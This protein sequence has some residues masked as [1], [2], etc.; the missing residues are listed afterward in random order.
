MSESRNLFS[1]LFEVSW[2]V[3]NK[4]GGIYEV[5]T[6]KVLQAQEEFGEDYFLLGPALKKNPDFIETDEPIWEPIRQ[7]LATKDLHCRLGRWNI[8]GKPK[9]ILVDFTNRHN[10]NQILFELWQKY[11]VDSLS[12]GFDYQEP[13]MFSYVCGEVI[14]AIYTHYYA[15]QGMGTLAHFHEWMCGAGLL[16]TKKIAPEVGTIFTTH[17]T[18]LGRAL[19]GTSVDIYKEMSS[20]NPKQAA[21]AHGIT[22]KCSM[23]IISA[24]EADAFTTVS[25]ITAN[26]ASNFLGRKPD[27]VTTN[28][29]DMRVMPNYS[30]ERALA[31][32]CRERLLK[33]CET[34]LRRKATKDIKI[35]TISGRY[36]YHNKGIDLFLDALANLDK[37]LRGSDIKV[38][39]L[40]LVMGGHHGLNNEAVSGDPN[41]TPS[42]NRHEGYITP[43]KVYDEPNDNI[44]NTCK[45]L[46]LVNKVENNVMVIFVPAMLDG[47]DGFFNME[48]FDI[49]AGSDLGV[50]PSWYEPWGYTPHESAAYGV[51]T[52]TTDLSGFGIWARDLEKS[53]DLENSGVTV[54]PRQ[55]AKYDEVVKNLEN[56]LLDFLHKSDDEVLELR[57]AARFVSEQSTWEHFYPLYLEAYEIATENAS[58]RGGNL[59]GDRRR[60]LFSKM[61]TASSSTTPL[62]RTFTA[63]AELP[64][65]I[66]RLRELASNL[67]WVWHKEAKHLF[68]DINPATWN[69]IGHN[70]VLAIEQA[71]PEK[72][73]ELANNATYMERY[74]HV[75]KDFDEY[76]ATPIKEIEGI[77]TEQKPAAYFCC[78]FGIHESLPIYSGGLGILAGDHMKSVSDLALPV[79]GIGLL[80]RNGYFR[81]RLNNE[82]KQEAIYPYND[83]STLPVEPVCDEEGNQ[84]LIELE[85]P[86]R[87]VYAAVWMARVGRAKLYL[88]DTDIS[89]NTNDD[90]RITARLYEADRDVRLRQEIVLGIGG[91]RLC[92]KLGFDPCVFHMNEGHSAF[93]IFERIRK[94]IVEDKLSLNQAMEFV[95]GS[96]VFT[97]HTPVDAG[98]ERF[99]VDQIARYFSSWA[100][101]VGMSWNNFLHLGKMDE[102]DHRDF[103][104]TVLALRFSNKSNGVSWLH[105]VVSRKMWRNLW[106][107]FALA[108]VPISHITNGIHTPS[109]VGDPFNDMLKNYVSPEWDKL[110]TSD[111]Q[112]DKVYSIP[113]NIFWETKLQQKQVLID[114]IRRR[115][116]E[117]MSKFGIDRKHT[118]KLNENLHTDALI[119]GF[120][121]RFAPY[122]RATLL[123][124]DPDRLAHILSQAGR[125]VV[126]VFSGKSHPADEKGSELIQDVVKFACEERFH[127]KIFFV[128]DYSLA[129]SKGLVQG[130]DVWLNNPRRPYEA[131]GTSGQKVPVNGGINFSISDG[132]WCEGY[133]GRNGWTIGPVIDEASYAFTEQ[134]DYADA[135][136]LYTLL[137][138]TLISTYYDR[139]AENIPNKWVDIA[140]DSLR[141]LTA[142]Y[143]T[144]RMVTDYLEKAY[145]PTARRYHELHDNSY[146]LSISNAKWTSEVCNIFNGVKIEDIVITGID[147]DIVVCGQPFTIKANVRHPN[148]DIAHLDVQLVLGKTEG[149]DFAT[150]PEVLHLQAVKKT[151]TDDSDKTLTEFTGTY[152]AKKNGRYA[153]GIRVLPVK[154]GV[155]TERTNQTILWG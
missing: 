123:F 121:R 136:S 108:E 24:R 84:V 65:A 93:L 89:K 8:P 110:P 50:F 38:C 101:S 54:I 135:E 6:S 124:A 119:I 70:P 95:N 129:I 51:P 139:N 114:E 34:L 20:I 87:T 104:M 106:N 57:K 28:G 150:K 40:F 64:P 111:L 23:E 11:G 13:V 32:E 113:D 56:A 18:M 102:H 78:E 72:L 122:K 5:I 2:E 31:D 154:D 86:G 134:D 125:P 81:Q 132:W 15:Q 36:E 85:M 126:F 103:N 151:A 127:G 92:Y 94:H 58:R 99:N 109:F 90:R 46:G 145:L 52:I 19:A 120:A 53:I 67:W 62:L 77:I 140:K 10:K 69:A 144:N 66:S 25:E 83:F 27:V 130:C 49:L 16:A 146:E 96:C 152:I 133:N 115:I 105:G 76:M 33:P 48:Y 29:L 138:E 30:E 112:W 153:F 149:D 55:H 80:Y 7:A 100:Q 91:V 79:I 61:L 37:S 47:H 142:E 45:N 12:G 143:S 107:G 128:E 137:E 3:C 73:I 116:P 60:E 17:A 43:F 82:G 155:C 75:L 118:H 117:F 131:S 42:E 97:T 14:S 98:N 44:L 141:T 88:L 1:S 74:H 68:I 4:V 22:A 41:L 26:E 35:L 59:R 71:A 21:A 148:I 147:G 9:V 63:V 39:A